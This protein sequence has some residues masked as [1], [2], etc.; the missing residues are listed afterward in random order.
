MTTRPDPTPFD[1]PDPPQ[2]PPPD[3]DGD[4]EP[5]ADRLGEESF[6]GSDPPGVGGP[7]V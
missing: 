3:E 4:E 6:P 2:P 1:V 5:D 7:G